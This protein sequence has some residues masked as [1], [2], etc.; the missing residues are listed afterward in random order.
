MPLARAGADRPAVPARRQ[1]Q[2]RHASVVGSGRTSGSRERY[3]ATVS[4][5]R[6]RKR[7]R[8]KAAECGVDMAELM[9]NGTRNW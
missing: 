7:R 2:P 4:L 3:Y 8:V 5:H 1:R 6:L 9:T